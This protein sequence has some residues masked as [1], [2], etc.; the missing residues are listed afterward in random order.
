MKRTNW[1]Y[2]SG[3]T[4]LLQ[5][6]YTAAI[7]SASQGSFMKAQVKIRM[8]VSTI[9]GFTLIELL[10][11]IA[12]IAILAGMLLPALGNAKQ[13]AMGTQC[14]SNTKQLQ[15]AWVL[16][17]GDNNEKIVR[18]PG[19]VAANQ[20]NNSWCVAGNRPGAT[21]YVTGGETNVNLFMH[22][23]LGKYAQAPKLFKCPADRNVYPGAKGPFARSFSMNNWMAGYTRGTTAAWLY[24]RESEMGKPGD[25][26]VFIH[27]DPN[28]IDDSTIAIDVGPGNTN[29]WNNSN[30]PA[31]LHNNSG[32]LGFADGRAELKKWN[33]VALATAGIVGVPTVKRSV[34]SADAV[35]LKTRT[36][37]PK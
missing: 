28:S 33:E 34:P 29:N 35:W 2:V 24:T 1:C 4:R 30:V 15:L 23:L 36:T 17:T 21:G 12:I 18:N 14:L 5:M 3:I 9:R 16:Y 37:E 19:A 25:L 27:E 6:S 20:T 13:K 8:V 26:F 32:S 7:R 10:V 22:G 11:V 31:A